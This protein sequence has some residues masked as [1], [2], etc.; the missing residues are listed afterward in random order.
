MIPINRTSL[1]FIPKTPWKTFVKKTKYTISL[2]WNRFMNLFCGRRWWHPI[3]GLKDRKII[4]GALPRPS[5]LPRL[6]ALGV[7][8]VLILT[9]EFENKKG[10]AG[11]PMT[12]EGWKK[13]NI[14]VKHLPTADY[15]SPPQNILDEGA[16]YIEECAKAGKGVYV[17]CK[18]GRGRSLAVLCAYILK[19]QPHIGTSA[20]AAIAH[21]KKYRSHI[22]K[23]HKLRAS[24]IEYHKNL[25]INNNII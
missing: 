12:L 14:K 15:K 4:L 21:V 24:L 16:D 7:G 8:S 20:D 9:E 11:R 6:R 3:G 19:Y 25:Q 17:H 18:A 22:S 13:A 1:P 5:H 2:I 10:I 23:G